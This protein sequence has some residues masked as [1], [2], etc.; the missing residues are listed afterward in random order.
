VNIAVVLHEMTPETGGGFAFQSSLVNSLD[1]VEER[2]HHKFRYW[3][4][5]AHPPSS[6]VGHVPTNRR[7]LVRN[8]A[9]EWVRDVQDERLGTRVM[10]SRPR[11]DRRLAKHDIDLVWFASSYAEDTELPFIFTVWDIEYI[12]QPWWP[13]VSRGGEWERRH[14][15]YSRHL[16]RATRVIV[17][18]AAGTEQVLQHFPVNRE[19]ILELHHPTPDL[20]SASGAPDQD[21]AL[22]AAVGATEPY[23]FYPAQFWPHKNHA[24]LLRALK[25][26]PSLRA[27]FTGAEKGFAGSIERMAQSTGVAERVHSLGFVDANTLVALYR[28][29]HALVYPSWFGPENLPP[30]EAFA[31]GCPVIAADV[32][33][34]REQ[35]GAGALLFPP[36]DAAA[37]SKAIAD[38]GDPAQRER[39][40]TE[41]RRLAAAYNADAYVAGVVDFLDHFERLR[42]GWD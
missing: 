5:S 40:T 9:S 2:T 25:Q 35:L 15:Y 24:T 26:Q 23:V 10:P 8:R 12:R 1:K 31:L 37:L 32:P 16:P 38:V 41:G 6:P 7:A 3:S 33:G 11:L 22:R 29:A 17:P 36:D 28:G 30:L 20:A 42:Q 13:E 18:N 14:R 39:L 27:V 34:A 21:A 4:A 19:R